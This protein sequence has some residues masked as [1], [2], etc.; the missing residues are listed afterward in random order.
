MQRWN[1]DIGA[2]ELIRVNI[3]FSYVMSIYKLV[4]HTFDKFK[5]YWQIRI[6]A[7]EINGIHVFCNT[8]VILKL[9]SPL[10]KY[11]LAIW[12]QILIQILYVHILSRVYDVIYSWYYGYT[13]LHAVTYYKLI[14]LILIH[15]PPTCCFV[16]GETQ[17]AWRCRSG[18]WVYGVLRRLTVL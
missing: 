9:N 17:R 15:F 8:H 1:D 2:T 11:V 10:S 12:W 14:H 6:H 3:F 5:T 13:L 7:S 18:S 16:H 4:E